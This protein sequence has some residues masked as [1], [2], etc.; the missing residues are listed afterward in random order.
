M[1]TF[2]DCSFIEMDETAVLG[3]A[4]IPTIA[5]ATSILS[6]QA[7]VRI[8][9]LPPENTTQAYA[10]GT[11]MSLL[12][13]SPPLAGYASPSILGNNDLLT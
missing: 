9:N 10:S 12:S 6:P 1:A 3:A 2:T 7:L 4:T 5:E 8:D 13:E 11:L